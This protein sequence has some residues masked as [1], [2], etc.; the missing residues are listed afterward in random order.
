MS[1]SLLYALVFVVAII[2]SLTNIPQAIAERLRPNE[3][4]LELKI[5]MLKV[6]RQIEL[7]KQEH[8]RK[9]LES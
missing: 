4:A 6:K 8:E 3:R 7:D 9:L 5:E 2:C 1:E